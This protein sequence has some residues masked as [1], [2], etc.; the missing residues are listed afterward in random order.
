M[1]K[2]PDDGLKNSTVLIVTFVL[3]LALVF[4]SFNKGLPFSIDVG[5]AATIAKTETPYTEKA[6]LEEFRGE[7][8]DSDGGLNELVKGTIRANAEIA[9]DECANEKSLVEYFCEN[10]Q[11]KYNFIPTE[12]KYCKDGKIVDKPKVKEHFKISEKSD[13]LEIDEDLG[14]VIE[15]V[16]SRELNALSG[17]SI[18]TQAG[19]TEYNQYIRFNAEDLDSG[20]VTYSRDEKGS[21]EDFL[22]FEENE[23][24]FEYELEFENG[25]RSKVVNNV[26]TDLEDEKLNILGR[27]YQVVSASVSSGIATIEFMSGDIYDSLNE[28]E[29]KKYQLNGVDYEVE[30]VTITDANPAAAVLK[31]N[32]VETNQLEDGDLHI[33]DN[34]VAT[35]IADLLNTEAGEGKD[36]VRFYLNAQ[37]FEFTDSYGDDEF[38]GS[39]SVN[40]EIIDAGSTKI[41]GQLAGGEFDFS[42]LKYRL[43]ADAA[44]GSN[45]Y[46]AKNR[47]LRDYLQEPEAMF[48]WDIVY[49]GMKGSVGS[50]STVIEIKPRGDDDYNLVFGNRNG[51]LYNIPFVSNRNGDFKLGSSQY[52]LIFRESGSSSSYFI[53][54]KDLFVVNSEDSSSGYSSVLRYDGIDVSNNVVNFDDV[55]TGSKSATYSGTPGTDATGTLTAGG[56]SFR[57]YV[58]PAPDY[59]LSMDLDASGS[60]DSGEAKIVV[61]GGGILDLGSTNTPGGSFSITLTTLSRLRDEP[62]KGDEVITINI[63]ETDGVDLNIPDQ[64]AL[65]MNS[66]Y[67]ERVDMTPVGVLVRQIT[68]DDADRL[69]IGYGKGGQQLADVAIVILEQEKAITKIVQGLTALIIYDMF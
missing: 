3:A 33:D 29:S 63:L 28:G 39:V 42:S 20:S 36:I 44:S 30:A 19:R 41:K 66:V 10:K 49:G 62:G 13:G 46:V 50:S 45:I 14:D 6:L 61:L 22:Y 69:I 57:F 58:G 34:G 43:K 2:Y 48:G 47:G 11:M 17:G 64:D 35:G 60:V 32:G 67:G 24:M 23:D 9:E 65:N 8:F 5:G 56:T 18:T 12:D 31:I 27:E 68:D 4:L 54:L 21:T 51:N 53:D 25:L 40:K 16:T 59:Q 55:A 52:D 15:A 7:C 38:G 37:S 26:L 1:T